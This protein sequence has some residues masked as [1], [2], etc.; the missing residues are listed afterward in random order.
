MIFATKLNHETLSAGRRYEGG[1]LGRFKVTFLEAAHLLVFGS[2][3]FDGRIKK[4]LTPPCRVASYKVG[5]I[6]AILIE[7]P[8]GRI[9]NVGSVNYRERSLDGI[10]AD[11][12]LLGIAGFDT[13][14]AKSKNK[15]YEGAVVN[16][17]PERIF[18]THWDEKNNP[19]D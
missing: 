8:F 9:L 6:Y 11:Y 3:P 15:F 12:L 1:G 10:K 2:V 14:S 13:Q 7:H 19:A 5:K 17:R 18:F 4:P 16:T